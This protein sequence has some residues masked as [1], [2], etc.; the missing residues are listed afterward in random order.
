MKKEELRDQLKRG[1]VLPVYVL[2]GDEVH[3]RDLAAKTIAN[4]VFGEGDLRDFN[5]SNIELS[6]EADLARAI[7]AAEQLPMMASRRLVCVSG[8]RITQGGKNDTIKEEHEEMLKAYLS[9]PCESSVIVFVADE[10][11]GVRKMGKLLRSQPGAVDFETLQDADLAKWAREKFANDGVSIDERAVRHLIEIVGNDLRRLSNEV[12]KLC[13]AS[14][15]TRNVSNDLIDALIPNR[16][17]LSNFELT[18]RLVRR[19]GVGALN[20]LRKVLDDGAEP[21]MLVGLISYNFR[22]MMIAASMMQNGADRRQVE[23]LLRLRYNDQEHFLRF[24]RQL[25]TV[26]LSKAIARIAETDIALKTSVGGGGPAGSRMLI[27]VL[28][29]ELASAN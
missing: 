11:N 16:R 1:V 14:L 2:Y 27:E 8:V 5:E 18:D 29:S 13:I 21:V 19:D 22:R 6:G 23:Q 15:P 12:E 4:R 28:V 25:G 26:G 7:A 24:S 20:V 3:L 10:L 17:E 9:R